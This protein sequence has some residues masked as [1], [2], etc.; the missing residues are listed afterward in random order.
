[1][2]HRPTT[3]ERAYQLARS[4]ECRTLSDIKQRLNADGHERI[5][6]HLYGASVSSALRKLCQEHYVGGA[7]DPAPPGDDDDDD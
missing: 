2:T 3:I 1:M 7:E 6:E 5:Q 4:G